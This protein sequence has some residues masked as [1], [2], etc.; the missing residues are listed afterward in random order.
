MKL[1]QPDRDGHFGI[2]GGR[3]A[4]ETLMPA[5]LELEEAYRAARKDTAFQKEF[6]FYLREYAGRE[7]PLY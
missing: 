2:F 1:T 4:A 3:Y 7:T 5:L 6:A